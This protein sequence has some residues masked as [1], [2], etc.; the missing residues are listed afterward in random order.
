MQVIDTA[1]EGVKIILP[2]RHG[3]ARGYFSEVYRDDVLKAHGI[4]I[5]FVQDNQSYSRDRGV[6][7]GLHF[8]SPP[9][10]QTKLV[11][12]LAG[13]V[14]DVAVDIRWGSPTFGRHVAVTLTGDEG[15]QLL[16]PRGFAHGFC[17]LVPDT[18]VTYKVDSYY[19]P[20]S[21]KGLAW[22]DPALGI[23]WPIAGADLILSDK[24]RRHP[25]LADLPRWFDHP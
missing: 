22:D 1:L 10:A 8:Q 16:V 9:A 17:T 24:D 20:E 3:D 14:I 23:D 5:V 21:D 18:V 15:N 6:L 11:R 19:A 4:S 13:A 2:A 7:R 25:R 12:V